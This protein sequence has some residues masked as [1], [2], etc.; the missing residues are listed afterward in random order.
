MTAGF[1][2]AG[3]QARPGVRAAAAYAA[4]ANGAR[5]VMVKCARSPVRGPGALI[6][7]W[8]GRRAS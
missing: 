4:T 5:L 1:A 6:M 7:A 2:P 8:F 3:S